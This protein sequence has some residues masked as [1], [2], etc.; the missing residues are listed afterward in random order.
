M[1]FYESFADDFDSRV[2]M[3][4]TEKRLAVVYHE[5]MPESIRGKRLLDAG[6]GTGWFSKAASE[7]GAAVTSLDLGAG[8]LRQVRRKCDSTCVVGSIMELPFPDGCF[9]VVVSSEVIE[10]IPDPLLGVAELYRVLSPGGVLVLTTPNKLWYFSVWLANG[11][12]LRPYQGLENWVSRRT[13]VRSARGLGFRVE[14]IVGIHLV[15]FV[16]PQL[17]PVLDWFHQYNGLLGPLMVNTA[18]RCR[19]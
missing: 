6:S 16:L 18:I 2:N 5:M 14:K 9:D 15:P 8:L 11:L 12:K 7:R 17:H 19:K 1:F 4:D 13:L 3:Y 10:H